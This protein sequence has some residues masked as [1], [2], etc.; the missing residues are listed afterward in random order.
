MLSGTQSIRP[1]AAQSKAI[2]PSDLSSWPHAKSRGALIAIVILLTLL[3]GIE[4][5]LP[6]STTVQIGADE[7]FELA[8]A[9][10]C[11]N[12]HRLYSEVWNDQP[13]LHTWL[14][15]RSIEI[16]RAI[17]QRESG[18]QNPKSHPAE[19]GPNPTQTP[20]SQISI[21]ALFPRLLT[22]V[23]TAVLLSSL[24]ILVLRISGLRV[25]TIT[26]ALL[27]LSPGFIELS[28]S[29]ML[30]IPA[31]ACAFAAMCILFSAGRSSFFWREC[32][33]GI[34][35]ACALLMKLVP[36]YLL[37]L[38]AAILWFRPR[39]VDTQKSFRRFLQSGLIFGL[40][41]AAAFVLIDLAIERGA[42]LVHFGQSW[43]SHFG[44]ATT[45][46]YGSAQQHPFQWSILLKNWD[47]ALPAVGAF[48]W[49]I[50][51]VQSSRLKVQR[52]MTQAGKSKSQNPNP[53]P[54]EGNRNSKAGSEQ[55]QSA[56]SLPR[57][58]RSGLLAWSFSGGWRLNV[59]I[60]FL[61]FAWLLYSLILFSVH[62]PWW[63]YYYIHTVI[64]LCWCAA[65]A[66]AAAFDWAVSG[67][68]RWL[69]FAPVVLFSMCALAWMGGRLYLQVTGIR[70]LPRNYE[71]LAIDRVQR[72][73]PSVHWM[74]A[75]DSIYSFWT[76]VPML[77]NLAVLPMKRFWMGDMTFD[78]VVEELTAAKPEVILLNNSS[79][80][81]PF[82]DL[83]A[84]DYRLTFMDSRTRLYV[85]RD[86]RRVPH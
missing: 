21:S 50:V 39:D 68:R 16:T 26:A 53:S 3:C 27:L 2:A 83:L 82:D 23:F 12:G 43:S 64:P 54:A 33:G 6:L 48:V 51:A 42:F 58:P 38:T 41:L 18:G 59:G 70:A 22:V 57:Q 31:L 79:E 4:G 15:T 37:P 74:Y 85:R 76:G 63:L 8:K 81:R 5:F 36:A 80:P 1:E 65:L 52:E 34:L 67:S 30:E 73:G 84:H 62:K 13:A 35:Y 11:L 7:G 49:A 55:P 46:E 44:R 20:N 66:L 78:R 9:T 47:T 32:L 60:S 29:C 72:L 17:S 61:P 24:F 69:R 40:S 28:S 19:A 25:A 86:I 71:T 77:P 75:D 14:V 56:A 45:L 10:L